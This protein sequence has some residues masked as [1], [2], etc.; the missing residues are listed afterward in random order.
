[1]MHTSDSFQLAYFRPKPLFLLPV[2]TE[3]G[4]AKHTYQMPS[5]VSGSEVNTET[6]RGERQS[7]YLLRVHSAMG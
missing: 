3:L 4:S 6:Q 1:M 2:D 7:P 5:C